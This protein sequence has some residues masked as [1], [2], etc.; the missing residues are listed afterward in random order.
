MF[1]AKIVCERCNRKNRES[2]SVYSRGS[3]FCSEACLDAWAKDNPPPVAKGS[4][5]ALRQET[6]IIIDAALDEF[7]RVFGLGSSNAAEQ[8][9]LLIHFH[10]DVLRCAPLLRGLGHT[11][12][13][14]MIEATDIMKVV[15]SSMTM[16]HAC[17]R[18]RPLAETLERVRPS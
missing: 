17:Q 7:H 11:D 10:T 12:A 1:W 4:V 16:N 3:Y 6:A 13:A 9:D 8:P 14:A 18:L 5:E 2:R 15:R